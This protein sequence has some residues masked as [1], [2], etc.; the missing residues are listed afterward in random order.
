MKCH[1]QYVRK[2]KP[3]VRTLRTRSLKEGRITGLEWRGKG[4]LRRGKEKKCNPGANEST[5]ILHPLAGTKGKPLH[6]TGSESHQIVFF[7]KRQFFPVRREFEE[8]HMK[9]CRGTI[10]QK[11]NAFHLIACPE[12]CRTLM[13]NHISFSFCSCSPYISTATCF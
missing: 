4:S 11:G 8:G 10:F 13:T 6:S 7:I 1:K 5:V 3:R 2:D 9:P 12:A